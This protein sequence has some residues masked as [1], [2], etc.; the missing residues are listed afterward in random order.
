MKTDMN[1][2]I[3]DLRA[4][5]N[6][7]ARAADL[8]AIPD[9]ERSTWMPSL[10]ELLERVDAADRR[11]GFFALQHCWSAIAREAVIR[12]LGSD[13]PGSRRMAAIVLEHG[14]G[15]AFLAQAASR[16]LD[17]PEPARAG[18]A[19]ALVDS[20]YPDVERLR[21]AVEQPALRPYLR[22]NLS[23][24]GD[25]SLAAAMLACLNDGDTEVARAGLAALIQ[26]IDPP[27]AVRACCRELLRHP[28]PEARELAAEYFCWHGGGDDCAA[29][30]AAL[31]AET[32]RHAAAGLES[33]LRAIK[34]RSTAT[35]QRQALRRHLLATQRFEPRWCYQGRSPGT[36]FLRGRQARFDLLAAYYGLP[37][38]SVQ[39]T[40]RDAGANVPHLYSAPLVAPIRQYPGAPDDSFGVDTD[41]ANRTYTELVHVGEDVGWDGEAQT[42]VAIADGLIREI[43]WIESWGNI[44]VVEHHLAGI[45]SDK[46]RRQLGLF[47][48]TVRES[49]HLADGS[50]LCCSVYAHLGPGIWRLPGAFI[51]AGEKIGVIGRPYMWENGGYRAHLHFATHLGPYWQTPRTGARI[52]LR[53]EGRR[54]EGI[55]RKADRR[56]IAATI[57]VGGRTKEVVRN[58][59]WLCG[60]V[61]PGHFES[62]THGWFNPRL[63]FS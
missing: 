20:M 24:Y 17:D 26:Q 29:L 46:L 44:A 40:R 53:F 38:R 23:R 1:E 58:T 2:L 61:S 49:I 8:S 54:Y 59:H 35:V 12:H 15:R 41:K 16:W 48:P 19:L 50:F 4:G 11:I 18:E 63:L 13:D 34:R 21:R 25:P 45:A 43:G 33:S 39:A 31:P 28:R 27:S 57:E 7:E 9:Q 5:A 10:L 60:Y 14:E 22:C 47:A 42:V 32:D 6:L 52:D 62:G 56:Q 36:D 51:E 55:V 37:H 3:A 30:Q